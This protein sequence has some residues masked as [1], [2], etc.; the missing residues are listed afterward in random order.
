MHIGMK[1]DDI[2][3][4]VG[5][6]SKLFGEAPILRRDDYAKWMLED[7]CVNFSVDLHGDGPVGSAHFG[8]QLATGEDLAQARTAIDDA[9][10]ERVDQDDLVCGYQ[11]QDKS[12]VHDPHGVAWEIFHTHGL[13]GDGD[14]YGCDEMP[15]PP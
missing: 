10:L 2:G 9:R 11:L 7:P 8:I 5:F 15:P 13:A 14:A 6:Y 1:V 12:W 4:A 3:V